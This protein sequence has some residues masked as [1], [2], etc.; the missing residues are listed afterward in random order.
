MIPLHKRKVVWFG[1]AFDSRRTNRRQNPK[2][3]VTEIRTHFR[4]CRTDL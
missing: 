4:G 2:N 3:G 1:S